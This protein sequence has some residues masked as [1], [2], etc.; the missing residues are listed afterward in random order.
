MK[1]INSLTKRFLAVVFAVL[2]FV[3]VA[4]VPTYAGDV[5]LGIAIGT[6]QVYTD[7]SC[8]KVYG[9]LEKCDTFTILG[10]AGYK[11]EYSSPDGMKS[12]YI[13]N[14][15]IT[16]FKRSGTTISTIKSNVDVYYGK[17]PSEFQLAGKV[18][19]GENVVVLSQ[20]G[21]WA[22]IEYNTTKGR[23]RGFIDPS[24]LGK[25]V[26]TTSEENWPF[27][28]NG[29]GV[30]QYIEGDHIIYSG[31]YTTYSVEGKVFDGELVTIHQMNS[32]SNGYSSIFITYNTPGTNQL[33]S[34]YIVYRNSI[35][36]Y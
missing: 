35:S 24:F 12:G 13:K 27:I 31:P 8:Q 10:G 2:M 26:G 16:F 34:G 14:P 20:Y 1:K 30:L 23:K 32:D 22:Y 36:Y 25:Y 11:I 3:S 21:G 29:K 28:R 5:G 19:E 15:P 4:N 33:K 18:Y 17:S 9:K 6:T 7:S